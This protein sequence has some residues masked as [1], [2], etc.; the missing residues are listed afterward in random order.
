MGN[1]SFGSNTY[2]EHGTSGGTSSGGTS[3][4]GGSGSDSGSTDT[5]GSDTVVVGGGG[6]GGRVRGI[7]SGFPSWTNG[8]K[9]GQDPAGGIVLILLF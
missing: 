1:S 8:S 2:W 4:G 3:G 6:G 7:A 9:I 5:T